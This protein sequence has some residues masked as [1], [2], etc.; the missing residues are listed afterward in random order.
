MPKITAEEF[1]TDPKHSE[2]KSF[3]RDIFVGI[4]KEEQETQK[5]NKKKPPGDGE[6]V[7]DFL[8]GGGE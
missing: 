5:K 8:F 3:L 2:Q 4:A 1:L 6:N 7:F